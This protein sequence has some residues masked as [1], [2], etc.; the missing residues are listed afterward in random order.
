LLLPVS[1]VAGQGPDDID[2][3]FGGLHWQALFLAVWEQ[4][5]AVSMIVVLT[6]WFRER[7]NRQGRLTRAL[8][9]SAYSAYI[10]HP[11]VRTGLA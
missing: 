7:F 8:S 9:A 2:A 5:M 3:F 10:I 6:V 11:L 1:M 4:M